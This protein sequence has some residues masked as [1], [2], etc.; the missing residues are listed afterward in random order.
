MMLYNVVVPTKYGLMCVNRNDYCSRFPGVG[1]LLMETGEYYD[2]EMEVIRNVIKFLPEDSVSYDIG[3]NVGVHTLILAK[4]FRQGRVFAFEPQRLVF[5]QLVANVALNSLVNAYPL[6]LAVGAEDRGLSIPA[7]DP[8]RAA[9]YGS[10][11]LGRNQIEDI[12]Q[13]PAD[14]GLTETVNLGKLDSL[15]LPDPAFVKIDVEGMELD[16]LKGGS[17]TIMRARPLMFIEYLKNDSAV[18]LSEIKGMGYDVYDFAPTF[19]YL[20]IP[21][22]KMKINGLPEL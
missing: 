14:N 6:Q 4:H 11:E 12:G 7:L 18:L 2:Q 1:R 13:W 15:G 9:S 20:C 16:V 8:F 5:H 19:N 10:L 3:A 22:E 17:R 21:S